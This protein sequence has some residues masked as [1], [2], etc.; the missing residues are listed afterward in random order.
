MVRRDA[1]T[2]FASFLFWFFLG[3]GIVALFKLW[4]ENPVAVF[5]ITIAGAILAGLMIRWHMIWRSQR[6][7]LG[8]RTFAIADDAL[9]V[10]GP[11]WHLRAEWR[12][13][14]SIGET[15]TYVFIVQDRMHGHVLPKRAFATS[16][17]ATDFVGELKRLVAR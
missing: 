7:Y 13:F 11:G 8:P 2:R 3:L 9:H 15:P 14:Q 1:V 5:L 4:R 16:E 10:S 6:A 12:C 17:A